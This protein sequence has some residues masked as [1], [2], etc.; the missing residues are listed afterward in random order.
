MQEIIIYSGLLLIGLVI[1]LVIAKASFSQT[2][3][4]QPDDSV[5]AEHKKVLLTQMQTQMEQAKQTLSSLESQCSALR[6]QVTECEYIL[7]AYDK[8]DEADDKKITFFGEHASP[9]LRMKKNEKRETTSAEHQPKDFSN[10]SSGL[11][12]GSEIKEK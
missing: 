1:G 5:A 4:N 11:F 7:A 10:S 9:Y 8:S 3:S 12:N 2:V 6:E